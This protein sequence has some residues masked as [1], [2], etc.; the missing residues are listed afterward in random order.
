[1]V[2][3]LEE[4]SL[5]ELTPGGVVVCR[6]EK[7]GLRSGFAG[8]EVPGLIF[9]AGRKRDEADDGS[10]HFWRKVGVRFLEEVCHL[11]E[12]MGKGA[13]VV[14]E[15][16]AT[17]WQ[18]WVL[19]A[20]PLRGGEYLSVEVL[21]AVWERLRQWTQSRIND[22]GGISVFLE[23]YAPNWSR[24]GRVTLHLAENPTDPENPFAFLATYATGLTPSG[25]LR[26]L[27]LAKALKEF[28]EERNREVLLRLLSPLHRASENSPLIADLIET[29]NI[30]QPILWSPAEAY[31]FLQSVPLFEEA[32]LLVRLPNWWKKRKGPRPQVAATIGKK[33]TSGVGLEGM[34]DFS[35]EVVVDGR[36]LTRQEVEALLD[37]EDG[38]VRLGGDWVEVNREQLQEALDHWRAV[39]EAGGL[40]MVEG[41]RLLAGAP[42]NLQSEEELEARREWAFAQPGEWMSEMLGQLRSPDRAAAPSSLEATLRPYQEKGLNWLWFCGQTGLGGCLADDMGLGKTIQVLAALLRRKEESPAAKTS[43]L[44]VPASLIGNWMREAGTFAPSLKLFVAHR[45][46]SAVEDPNAPDF[47]EVEAAD[48][49]ITTYGTLPRL[50]WPTER[51]WGWIILDEAQAIKNHGTRQSRAVRKLQSEARFALTGT[52]VENHLGDL[53]SIFDFLNPG[54]LGT[55]ST[56]QR[57][58]KNLRTGDQER[59]APLRRLVSPYILRRLKTDKSILDDLPEKTEMKVFCGLSPAQAKLYRESA[60]SLQQE[61][62]ASEGM[63]RKGVVL[64]YLMRFKQ[65]CNHPDQVAKSGHYAAAKSAKFQRLAELCEEIASRGEKVLVFTQFRELTGPLE[66]LLGTVFGRPGLIL[67]GG[68][69]V[70]E[71]SKRVD[72]FQRAE[73]PPFFVLSLKAGGTGL[74]LTAANHVI[75]FD[76]WWNPA[77]ENQ[78][79]DRAFRIGQKRNVLVHKFITRGTLEEKIDRMIEAKQQTADQILTG[80]A[81][82]ALTEMSDSELLDFVSLSI[83]GATD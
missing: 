78:A 65:I 7:G 51:M 41:M 71:R 69:P 31:Q 14:R 38:L 12:G 60:K 24:V 26:L 17:E 15:P 74:N 3:V 63:R 35:L 75:H 79:T 57:F 29:G 82:T 72:D 13:L 61:L 1:M 54:L 9:L 2:N 16:E 6:Q 32:G 33:R 70:K 83:P 37:G 58:V 20:P 34:L 52:P 50:R 49:V 19:N 23:A 48:L 39:E 40:S 45:S 68:T 43:L 18:E 22:V 55:A 21:S 8:G 64:T 5:L 28:S 81:E 30:F 10:V 47:A 42:G 62:I 59:F 53:W 46:D 4:T 11:P 66:E 67:H 73:G 36:T 56:F 76:R 44:V 25:E 80:G 77:I 27:P